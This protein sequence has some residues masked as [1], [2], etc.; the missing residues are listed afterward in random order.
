MAENVI[1]LP[2]FD[3][4]DYLTRHELAATMAC[5]VA[6]VDRMRKAGMPSVTWGRR[7]VRFPKS[8]SL[9]WAKA[10]H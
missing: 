10:Q 1:G 2:A 9:A 8:R 6:T 7:I 3:D 5:S 4:E